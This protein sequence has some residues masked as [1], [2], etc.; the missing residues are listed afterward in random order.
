MRDII[1]GGIVFYCLA[2]CLSIVSPKVF[3]AFFVGPAK[4]YEYFEYKL[5]SASSPVLDGLY[6]LDDGS[7]PKGITI[8]KKDQVWGD[9]VFVVDD[10]DNTPSLIDMDGNV[11][12]KWDAEFSR[13]WGEITHIDNPVS[14]Q[15]IEGTRIFMAPEMNGDIY[16]GYYANSDPYM[17]YYGLLKLDED[18]NVLWKN[19]DNAHHDAEFIGNDQMLVFVSYLVA[20]GHPNIPHIKKPIYHEYVV[21]LDTNTGEE[22][23]RVDIAEAFANSKYAEV[24]HRLTPRPLDI[25]LRPGDLFHPNG[26][27]KIPDHVIGKAPMLKENSVILSLRNLDMLAI[28]DL[29]EG[30]ITWA[31]FGPWRGQHSPQ[32]MDNG[33]VV[34]FDNF[35]SVIEGGPSRILEV[36]LNTSGVV[37]EY[38]GTK[39][40]PLFS[41]YSSMIDVLPNGNVFAFSSNGGRAFEVTRDKEIVWEYYVEG[42]ITTKS[43]VRI[44]NF[45]GEAK[46]KKEQL[47]FLD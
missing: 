39:D 22:L 21:W 38:T 45:T 15:H 44:P 5:V 11:V 47:P 30:I 2:I 31:S 17:P 19:E 3:D 12:H 40:Q 13:K 43:G 24:L 35:G 46:Y 28:L 14:S 4:Y 42:R 33:N 37:W 9:Y 23:K 18:S 1:I 10:A 25:A 32:F 20:D 6:K 7:Q 27:T 16:V 29:E 8:N 26:I 34:M 36:D 41:M